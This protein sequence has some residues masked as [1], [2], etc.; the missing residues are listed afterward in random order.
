MPRSSPL[1][2][3]L[4]LLTPAIYA[5]TPHALVQREGIRLQI[6]VEHST[7][8]KTVRMRPRCG[9]DTLNASVR[10]M[11]VPY[12]VTVPAQELG[13]QID[14]TDPSASVRVH[15]ERWRGGAMTG[16]ASVTGTGALVEVQPT[17]IAL[18]TVATP[19]VRPLVYIN[20]IPVTGDDQAEPRC[21]VSGDRTAQPLHVF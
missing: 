7:L 11:Q 8:P 5:S 9:F 19:L 21:L 1:T 14:A 18:Q 3:V 4:L 16:E 10:V 12:D 20:G 15:V 13:V 17:L 6:D 2:S